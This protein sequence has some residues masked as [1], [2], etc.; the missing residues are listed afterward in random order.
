VVLT[1]P[2]FLWHKQR[3]HTHCHSH[4]TFFS[5]SVVL[6]LLNGVFSLFRKGYSGGQG[7][8]LGLDL[9]LQLL[10][11]HITA[12]T[13]AGK[14]TATVDGSVWDRVCSRFHLDGGKGHMYFYTKMDMGYFTVT[15]ACSLGFLP[16]VNRQRD[17]CSREEW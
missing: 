15:T 17:T 9:V 2:F 12:T 11:L 13:A 6:L 10:L 4:D 5:L 8:E 16:V 14:M 7:R 3:T 1:T